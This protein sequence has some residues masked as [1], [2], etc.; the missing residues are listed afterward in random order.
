[1]V[2][3]D[4]AG[5]AAAADVMGRMGK[6]LGKIPFA[7]EA[8]EFLLQAKSARA[9]ATLGGMGP[10]RNETVENR[11]VGAKSVTLYIVAPPPS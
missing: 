1:M 10:G 11:G 4:W 5:A 8:L 6:R 2:G 3:Q 7:V 9:S